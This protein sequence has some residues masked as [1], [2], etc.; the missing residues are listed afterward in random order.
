MPS[1]GESKQEKPGNAGLDA[2]AKVGLWLFAVYSGFYLLFVLINT[3]APGTAEVV[4]VAGLNLAVVYGFGLILLAFILAV[5]YGMAC[6]RG[7]RQILSASTAERS[8]AAR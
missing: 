1:E 6:R 8:E 7:D 2:N 5:V 3:F 4:V